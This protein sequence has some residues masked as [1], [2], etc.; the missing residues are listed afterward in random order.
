MVRA[1]DPLL[2]LSSMKMETVISAPVSGKI[3]YLIGEGE[4]AKLLISSPGRVR[5]TGR[6][7]H[8]NE[9]LAAI[10]TDAGRE[11]LHAEGSRADP[12]GRMSYN[13]ESTLDYI[14]HDNFD[15]VIAGNLEKHFKTVSELSHAAAQG[16]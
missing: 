6:S 9:I 3:I 13:P 12:H 2:I 16:L 1:G 15:E 11:D 5:I 14:F 8:E 10:E 4:R 7:V